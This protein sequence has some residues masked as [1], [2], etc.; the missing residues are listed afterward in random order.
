MN[1]A[2]AF[3]E[4]TTAR[5]RP[6]EVTPY[7]NVPRAP[8]Q[9]AVLEAVRHMAGLFES[10]NGCAWL[11]ENVTTAGFVGVIRYTSSSSRGVAAA[12]ATRRIPISAAAA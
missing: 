6:P 9:E 4:V 1:D 5:L 3:P 11:I 7:T 10:G 2:P 12:S 8:D